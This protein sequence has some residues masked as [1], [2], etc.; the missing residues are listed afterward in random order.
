MKLLDPYLPKTEP[1]QYGFKEGGS[2]FALGLI[3]ANHGT[4]DCVKY[5][6]EQL[7]AAQTSAVRHGACLGLGLAAMGTQNQD[8]RGS[9]RPKQRREEIR[10]DGNWVPVEQ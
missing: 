10:C 3:H 6:R 2:L 5:L 8:V 4:A 9:Y 1:D 7:S